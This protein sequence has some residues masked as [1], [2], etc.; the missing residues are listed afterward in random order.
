MPSFN[1]N[2]KLYREVASNPVVPK[3]LTNFIRNFSYSLDVGDVTGSEGVKV[4]GTVCKQFL[5]LLNGLKKQVLSNMEGLIPGGPHL[6]TVPNLFVAHWYR[7]GVQ[8]TPTNVGRHWRI[9][10]MRRGCGMG[11]CSA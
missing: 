10:L 5:G 6:N 9:Y 4:S 1:L 2:G 3:R 11:A 7:R 8:Q